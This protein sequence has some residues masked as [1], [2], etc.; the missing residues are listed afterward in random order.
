MRVPVAPRGFPGRVLA[1]TLRELH[2]ENP[3]ASP[4]SA[5]RPA[6]ARMLCTVRGCAR[7][8]ELQG[9][10]LRCPQ[11]HAFDV[12]REGY[13]NLLLVQDRK[14]SDPGDSKE[15]VAARRRLQDAGFGRPLL[16][17]LE[18]AIAEVAPPPA[19][20]VLDV[21]CGEGTFLASIAERFSLEGHGVDISVSAIEAAAKRHPSL[22]WVVANADR[23]L[24][25]ADASFRLVLTIAGRRHPPEFARVLEPE[26]RLIAALPAEDDLIELREALHGHAIIV[27]RFG[28]L[29]KALEGTFQLEKRRVLRHRSRLETVA[30]L[31]LLA[32]TYRGGRD[33]Q[34]EAVARIE[35]MDVTSSWTLATFRRAREK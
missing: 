3:V 20:A 22:G 18:A 15:A 26:G 23:G 12:A 32:S 25:F 6:R 29:L 2:P 21:G 31:D 14:S 13:V 27:D 35:A 4:D 8:L 28:P 10:S 33:S 16:D 19:S 30:I 24:P 7:E 9:A 5:R 17:A 1:A 34:R 11:G